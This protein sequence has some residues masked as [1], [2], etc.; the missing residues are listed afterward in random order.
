[1][2][3]LRPNAGLGR[4]LAKD[5]R[6]LGQGTEEGTLMHVTRDEAAQA[7][8]EISEARS[9]IARVQIYHHGAPYL[10]VW[11]VVWLFANSVTHFLGRTVGYVWPLAIAFG[12]AASAIVGVVQ[13]RNLKPGAGVSLSRDLGRRFAA[14]AGLVLAF[15]YCV[16]WITQPASPRE[17]TAVISILFPFL[18]MFAGV[19]VGWRL[20]AIGL[21]AAA[22]IM[23]G[24]LNV[25]EWF[26][27]W[28]GVFAGGSLIAGGL[29]LRKA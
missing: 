22:A 24:Y 23:I 28:M 20:F 14:L 3:H 11:G 5:K 4:Q 27:L 13:R 17:T 9:N 15:I 18:Y 1:M 12:V 7:L 25:R 2:R 6:L 19:W 21:V 16:T 29:W 8:D 26:D 10:I